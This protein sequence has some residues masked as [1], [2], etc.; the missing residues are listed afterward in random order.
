VEIRRGE[1][2]GDK[3]PEL[4]AREGVRARKGGVHAGVPFSAWASA[5]L[6]NSAYRASA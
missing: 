6:R 2:A 1:V 5:R 4:K 3:L